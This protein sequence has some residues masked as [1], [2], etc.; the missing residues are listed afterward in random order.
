MYVCVCVCVCVEDHTQAGISQ[1]LRFA[2]RILTWHNNQLPPP[3]R[4]FINTQILQI[5]HD[6]QSS[7]ADNT[8]YI[9]LKVLC[10]NL[11]LLCVFLQLRD[12]SN[13]V[14]QGISVRCTHKH[15]PLWVVLA[16]TSSSHARITRK[17]QQLNH[18]PP[19]CFDV[20]FTADPSVSISFTLVITVIIDNFCIALFSSLH[21]LTALDNIL[22]HF[23]SFT[24]V[25]HIIMT[26][27]NV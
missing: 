9:T 4:F 23:L 10:K 13:G 26:T 14:Q 24:N 15:R 21:K 20:V 25:I 7:N 2:I 17:V 16:L 18:S 6:P 27:K 3:P 5:V 19:A 11:Q 12:V 22:Q 8:T 1:N